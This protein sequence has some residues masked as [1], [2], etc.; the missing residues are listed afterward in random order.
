MSEDLILQID[1]EHDNDSIDANL[2]RPRSDSSPKGDSKRVKHSKIGLDEEAGE[3]SDEVNNSDD[4]DELSDEENYID[5]GFVVMGDEELELSEEEGDNVVKT[6]KT[7]QKLKKKTDKVVLDEE[8]EL[9]ILDN[10]LRDT[11]RKEDLNGKKEISDDVSVDEDVVVEES[12]RKRQD[13]YAE[14]D[15][16]DLEDFIARED[17]EDDDDDDKMSKRRAIAAPKLPYR[18]NKEGPT[19][20]QV[21]EAI[22]I[23]GHGYDDQFSDEDEEVEVEGEYP[24]PLPISEDN[25]TDKIRSVKEKKVVQRLRSKFDRSQLVMGFCTDRDEIIRHIDQPERLITIS[26]LS[27]TTTTITAT[28]GKDAI[29]ASDADL[30]QEAEWL[31]HKLAEKIISDFSIED[32][33]LSSIEKRLTMMQ[34]QSSSPPADLRLIQE[35][36]S[37]LPHQVDSETLSA[38]LV[39]VALFVLQCLLVDHLDVPF[40]WTYRKDYLHQYMS[41][42]HLWVVLDLHDQW[43]AI[44]GM[45]QRI[46]KV[47]RTLSAATSLDEEVQVRSEEYSSQERLLVDRCE[48]CTTDLNFAEEYLSM[49]EAAALEN[50]DN[51]DDNE[52]VLGKVLSAREEVRSKRADLQTCELQLLEVQ[53]QITLMDDVRRAKAMF[54]RETA[55]L[56]MRLFPADRYEPMLMLGG[57]QEVRHIGQFLGLLSRE[58]DGGRGR[59]GSVTRRE[60]SVTRREGSVTRRGDDY[61]KHKVVVR[62]FVELVCI[63]ACDLGDGLRH[64]FKTEPPVTPKETCFEVAESY[65]TPEH[66]Y[67]SAGD[68]IRAVKTVIMHEIGNEPTVQRLA[69]EIFNR[70]ASVTTS[71]TAKGL[72]SINPFSEY[73]GLHYLDKK[74]LEDFFRGGDRTLYVRLMEAKKLGLIEVAVNPPPSPPLDI[75]H[76][77]GLVD[78]LLPSLPLEN[79]PHPDARGSWD[80]L[81]L[82]ILSECVEKILMPNLTTEVTRELV[83][84]GREVVIE[85]CCNKFDEM[86]RV[87]PYR[88]P[89]RDFRD[90]MKDLLLSTPNRP[91][92]GTVACIYLSSQGREESMYLAFVNKEGVLR[93]HEVLPGDVMAQKSCKIRDFLL[94]NR[95]DVVVINSSGGHNSRS[96]FI[97]VEKTILPEVIEI[98]NKSKNRENRFS[99]RDVD[100]DDDDEMATYTSH[101]IYYTYCFVHILFCIY[102]VLYT[103]CFVYILF[104][105]HIVLY[106]YILTLHM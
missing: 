39:P 84:L 34:Q 73:F 15:E 103:Y 38:E 10:Q 42:S 37:S 80:N 26:K 94:Q 96:T 54:S 105:I 87:G 36:R 27:S 75:A 59:E 65:I 47:I 85:E 64:G 7:W 70:Q 51:D 92:C 91:P 1:T 31:S 86:L 53:R 3:D 12:S 44:G 6:K 101:V 97:E 45:R 23:F 106:T 74:P 52:E 66:S 33:R 61:S 5:D 76:Q 89:H 46:V 24:P 9:L 19:F 50:N 72:V 43:T 8:D 25:A 81:R 63:P 14:E 17:D 13:L 90:D 35:K 56:V 68:V 78:K 99:S 32:Q 49:T 22:D 102:I 4:E 104:C 16:D 20:D 83:R 67:R 62:S 69:R 57:E 88:A 93:S 29:A 21:Q 55:L 18:R 58:K 77:M 71:P 98:V 60:G 41:S 40:I 100:D 2:K 11:E 30:E 95:P 82:E 79:D 48:N 28:N